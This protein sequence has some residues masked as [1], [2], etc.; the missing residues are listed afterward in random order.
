MR[1]VLVLRDAD[2]FSR[3]LVEGGV[4]VD[5]QLGFASTQGG[6]HAEIPPHRGPVGHGAILLSHSPVAVVLSRRCSLRR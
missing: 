2:E 5:L 6:E 3:V 4:D 1:S